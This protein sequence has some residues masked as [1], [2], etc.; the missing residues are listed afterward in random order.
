MFA[1]VEIGGK[2]Y[3]VQQG[4]S[5]YVEK[6]NDKKAGDEVIIDK[7]LMIDSNIGKPYIN[8]AK[9]VCELEKEGKQEKIMIIKHISQK[10]HTKTSAHRQPYAKLIIK[11][12]VGGK[13]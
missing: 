4:E 2:Q 13:I 8:G 11:D 12:I 5:I 10:H 6:I 9:V 7:V 1:I 3:K